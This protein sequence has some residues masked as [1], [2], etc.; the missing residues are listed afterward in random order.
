MNK[1]RNRQER[2]VLTAKGAMMFAPISDGL[3]ETIWKELELHALRH[4]YNAILI[5]SHGG[6]FIK[7]EQS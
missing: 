5:D 1:K 6:E 4:G 7:V 2:Y 3:A